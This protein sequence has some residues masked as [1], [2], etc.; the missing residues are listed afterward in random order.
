MAATTTTDDPLR[1]RLLARLAEARYYSGDVAGAEASATR[2]LTLAESGDD[3]DALVA[4]PA[5]P[6]S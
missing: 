1:A 4:A 2:A 3:P 6:A 5:G